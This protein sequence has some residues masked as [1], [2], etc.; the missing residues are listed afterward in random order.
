MVQKLLSRFGYYK[1]DAD[2][3]ADI[4]DKARIQA[5]FNGHDMWPHTYFDRNELVYIQKALEAAES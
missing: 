5:E 3:I 1:M 2:K 4:L